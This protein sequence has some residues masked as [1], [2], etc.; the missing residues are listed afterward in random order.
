MEAL[1]FAMTATR[2]G[3]TQHATFVPEPVKFKPFDLR[4]LRRPDSADNNS[5]RRLSDRKKWIVV[6]L[7]S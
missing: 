5:P 2:N 3:Y 6:P 7:A 4:A 1:I